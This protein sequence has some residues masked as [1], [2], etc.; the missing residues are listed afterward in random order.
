M[1]LDVDILEI[2]LGDELF[3][4]NLFNAFEIVLAKIGLDAIA[5]DAFLSVVVV[6]LGMSFTGDTALSNPEI[7][8]L[9]VVEQLTVVTNWHKSE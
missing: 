9:L 3:M 4:S 5:G 7:D 1:R 6:G 2:M 8:N